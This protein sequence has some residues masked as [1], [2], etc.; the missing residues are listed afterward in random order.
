MRTD[1]LSMRD[2]DV[3]P[4]VREY[5]RRTHDDA[6]VFEEMPLCR[7]ARADLA[8]VNGAMWGYEIKSERDTLAR[9][10][11]Q[12]PF[13]DSIFDYS[14]VVC[15]RCHVENTKQA[16][17][18]H[19]GVV[20]VEARDDGISLKQVRKPRRNLQTSVEAVIRLL[21]KTEVVK[22]LR[23]LQC[24]ANI[25]ESVADLWHRLEWFARPAVIAAALACLKARGPSPIDEPRAPG[26]D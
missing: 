7:T 20:V 6:V 14:T 23:D 24:K 8:A 9:L 18:S 22:V 19:W 17:P 21:W 25:N 5:I 12:I 16:V 1:L 4:A 13:Y 26:G 2:K 10:P 15:A 11:L 3:R